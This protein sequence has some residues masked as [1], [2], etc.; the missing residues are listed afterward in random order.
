MN[1]LRAVIN[2]ARDFAASL[3]EVS[4]RVANADRERWAEAQRIAEDYPVSVESVR[5]GLAYV[6][7]SAGRDCIPL[8]DPDAE[9]LVRLAISEA[10]A[11]HEPHPQ[12]GAIYDLWKASV[13]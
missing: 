13:T 11:V 3:R 6:R 10:L 4:E 12:Y 9:R 8:S 1:G 2:S 5:N 7:H